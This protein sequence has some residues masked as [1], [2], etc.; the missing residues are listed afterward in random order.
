MKIKFNARYEKGKNNEYLSFTVLD[1]CNIHE[2]IIY[3]STF[4]SDGELSNL[5]PHMYR[6]PSQKVTKG[7]IVFLYIHDLGNRKPIDKQDSGRQ[8]YRFLWGLS[9]EMNVFNK[10]GDYLHIAK[11]DETKVLVIEG[12]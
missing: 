1:D 12:K 4:D 2:Y 9:E 3:D 11:V 5:L 7:A 10:D 8:V 6:F